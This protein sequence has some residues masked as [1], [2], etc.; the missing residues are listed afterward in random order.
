MF[1]SELELSL[2]AQDCRA[3][4]RR[5]PFPDHLTAD[6]SSPLPPV[7][8][9]KQWLGHNSA[10]VSIYGV[11][12]RE[13]ETGV[14]F[15]TLNKQ[16]LRSCTGVGFPVN[17]WWEWPRAQAD[18]FLPCGPAERKSARPG[19][20]SSPSSTPEI[21]PN[22]KRRA[23]IPHEPPSCEVTGFS[24]KLSPYFEDT[25]LLS[26]SHTCVTLSCKTWIS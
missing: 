6:G 13:Q 1:G 17:Q 5:A 10:R 15:S 21:N 3:S 20:A 19:S 18:A 24:L 14:E 2:K 4:V 11:R 22:P 23:E 8:Y 16:G 12:L 26:S 9:A 25:L 7:C